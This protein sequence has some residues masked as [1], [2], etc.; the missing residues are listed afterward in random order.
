[1]TRTFDKALSMMQLT[2]EQSYSANLMIDIVPQKF[3]GN[4]DVAEPWD[5]RAA[6]DV[7]A[8]KDDFMPD[9][10]VFELSVG[11]QHRLHISLRHRNLK[12][13]AFNKVKGVALTAP[14]AD[15]VD[16]PVQQLEGYPDGCEALALLDPSQS[17]SQRL[18]WQSPSSGNLE[19]R[20]IP[21]DLL[22][23]FS[24][25]EEEPKEISIR[26]QIYVKMVRRGNVSAG[27]RFVRT[28]K[29][30]WQ[31]SSQSTRDFVRGSV[32]IAQLTASM[33]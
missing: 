30:L 10:P 19:T 29:K 2:F 7:Y 16:L 11:E 5:Q 3:S 21:L 31:N 18:R 8:F 25:D 13:L 6:E 14:D 27:S 32:F 15:P 20:Y 17:R 12:N 28:T 22:M 33:Y 23:V 1:M 9:D 24:T 4:S 26:H